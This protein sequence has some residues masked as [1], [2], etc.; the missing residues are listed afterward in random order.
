MAIKQI[1]TRPN[2]ILSNKTQKVSGVDALTKEILQ[3]LKDTLDSAK[4]P[5]GA[6][7]AANQLGYNKSICLVRRFYQDP[8][9]EQN[10]LSKDYFLINPK[11]ISH[12]KETD[13]RFEGC[14]SV[15][16]EY[17]KVQRYKKIKVKTLDAQGEPVRVTGTGFFGRTL[18]HE[19]DHLNGTL[20]TEKIIGETY[21]EEEL[22]RMATEKNEET[23][24]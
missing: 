14:L 5:E 2:E 17:G 3:D 21:T 24:N 8:A 23:P 13:V 9:D 12:S 22:E 6:G 16:D 19:I 20:F 11:I 10:T 1:V 15:P 18:Q 7:L 4:E